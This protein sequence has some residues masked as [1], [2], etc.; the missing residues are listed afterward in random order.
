[1]TPAEAQDHLTRLHACGCAE[2]WYMVPPKALRCA[3]HMVNRD[4]GPCDESVP[5]ERLEEALQVLLRADVDE[6][7][8][9]R[10]LAIES[11]G[12]PWNT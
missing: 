11:P 10:D 5:P 12:E 8:R 6:Q 4:T 9:R 7:A 2:Y 3:I 1:M